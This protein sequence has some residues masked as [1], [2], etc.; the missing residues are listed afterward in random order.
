MYLIRSFEYQ[1]MLFRTG[2]AHSQHLKI[3][4]VFFLGLQKP[5]SFCIA[6]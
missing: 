1:K 2:L 4:Y 5:I 6:Q 3:E